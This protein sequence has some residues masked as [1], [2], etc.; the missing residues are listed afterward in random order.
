M[1]QRKDK[2]KILD[3]EYTQDSEDRIN[4]KQV[5]WKGRPCLQT[6]IE[7]P[8][9]DEGRNRRYFYGILVLVF[10]FVAGMI[11]YFLTGSIIGS[12]FITVMSML[13][14]I[15]FIPPY[16]LLN[17]YLTTNKTA[18]WI[19]DDGII[20]NLDSGFQEIRHELSWK[21]VKA[22]QRKEQPQN[23]TAIQLM[24]SKKPDFITYNFLDKE[25]RQFPTLE[26]LENGEEVYRIILSSFKAYQRANG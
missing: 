3:Y 13:F 9:M 17:R 6:L 21:E 20:F 16:F 8:E 1:W 15:A 11:L 22:I 12:C 24:T 14:M 23:L 2:D 25:P 26:L 10:P 18:Y 5:I 4:E 7:H 19:K